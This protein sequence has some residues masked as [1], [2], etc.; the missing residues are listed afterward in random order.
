ML[1]LLSI[2][3][4]F[5]R[6]SLLTL[7][8]KIYFLLL[9][10]WFPYPYVIINWLAVICLRLVIGVK[11]RFYLFLSLYGFLYVITLLRKIALTCL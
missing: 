10:T 2:P 9:A 7:T 3:T 1:L 5:K 4:F 11:F 8:Y 6:L